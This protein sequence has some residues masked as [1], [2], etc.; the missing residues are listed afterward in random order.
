M[1]HKEINGSQRFKRRATV[2]AALLLVAAS[3]QAIEFDTGNPDLNLRW[4]NTVRY[5][6]GIRTDS[7]DDRL[8]R[9]PVTDESDNRFDKNS[10][11]TNRVD[12]L[13]EIDLAYK[14]Q[15]GARVSAAGWYDHAYHDLNTRPYGP[16]PSSYT[17]SRLNDEAARFMRGPSGE[18]LDAFVWGNVKLGDVPVNVRIG[19][20]TNYWGEGL[21]FGAH[22]ISYSQSPTDG[23]KAVASPGIETKEVFLPVGQLHAKAQLTTD[24]AVAAQYF[25]DWKP[26][27]APFGGS[28]F[29]AADF[30]RADRFGVPAA[31]AP[32]AVSAAVIATPNTG[33]LRPRVSGNW[34]VSA[35][36]KA[37]AI[38]S[39]LGLYYRRFDDYNPV[40]Q[41]A[42]GSFYRLTYPQGVSIVGASFARAISGWSV[43]GELS[44]RKDGALNGTGVNAAT[45]TGPRGNTWHAVLNGV[46]LLPATPL[47][48][49]GSV[50]M[51]VAY[52][53]LDK[54]TQNAALYNG[55]GQGSA[56]GCGTLQAAGYVKDKT[57]GC[58]TNSWLG[59]AVNFT[60]Q[61]LGALPSLDID[62]PMTLNYGI[63]GNAPTAGGGAQGQLTYS[64]GVRATYASKHELTLRYADLKAKTRYVA[65]PLGTVASGGSGSWATTDR[66]W[67]TLTYKVGF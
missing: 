5:N 61:Y 29:G 35:Q 18:I 7:K 11:V 27:R 21:L 67:L 9:N 4:D 51:E 8:L 40:P 45:T 47:F 43:A 53:R 6:L 42:P 39:M 13:S 26:T 23:V 56:A 54:V 48:E 65:S 64:I 34:G 44:Y 52:N 58:S 66:G 62:I 31:G 14:S 46:R 20:Q 57:D 49:T 22:A 15:F 60:P 25:Y 10:I 50:A 63:R 28:Y 16:Y 2:T 41:I 24:L 12:L 17:G 38:D 37:E 32:P 30:L 55:Y 59:V 3:V 19:R 33:H 1:K 36:Y